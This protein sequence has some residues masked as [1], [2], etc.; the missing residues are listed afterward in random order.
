MDWFQGTGL[1]AYPCKFYLTHKRLCSVSTILRTPTCSEASWT[2]IG[3]RYLTEMVNTVMDKARRLADNVHVQEEEE[4]VPEDG[5]P[6]DDGRITIYSQS[7]AISP[8]IPSYNAARSLVQVWPSK[9]ISTAFREPEPVVTSS[10]AGRKRPRSMLEPSFPVH[11][12]RWGFGLASRFKSRLLSFS[13]TNDKSSEEIQMSERRTLIFGKDA[14]IWYV[15]ITY[16]FFDSFI[17]I[18]K[19]TPD[20]LEATFAAT[21]NDE[22]YER[23]TKRTKLHLD[24]SSTS[25]SSTP[26]APLILKWD[27]SDRY[28]ILRL[29]PANAE[30]FS[31]PQY[32][33]FITRQTRVKEC[34]DSQIPKSLPKNT[35]SSSDLDIAANSNS[36][37]P[38]TV[39]AINGAFVDFPRQLNTDD[40]VVGPHHV[41]TREEDLWILELGSVQF[42]D[43]RPD[44]NVACDKINDNFRSDLG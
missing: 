2:Y 37:P 16:Y 25:S 39:G 24:Q 26:P 14:E 28:C 19:Y 12:P 7:H 34:L 32:A 33:M 5:G 31:A 36:E 27:D 20:S 42:K 23:P 9:S 18:Y 13:L 1:G 38:S 29:E 15:S 8:N 43:D 10:L 21:N 4:V 44:T 40:W 35:T 3:A 30:T 11:A 17:N 22:S 41:R 6:E